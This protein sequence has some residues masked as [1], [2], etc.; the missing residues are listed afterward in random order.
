M[1]LEFRTGQS[2]Q[3]RRLAQYKFIG[4]VDGLAYFLTSINSVESRLASGLVSD[5]GVNN[6][7]IVTH[8]VPV[9]KR[10][11]FA[12]MFDK[13]I[14]TNAGHVLYGVIGKNKEDAIGFVNVW[15]QVTA[16]DSVVAVTV[17][18]KE[19]DGLA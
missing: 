15:F 2:Y 10:K 1:A 17:D 5:T 8:I 4:I 14:H 9:V 12:Y 19:G 3:D 11:G 7:D 16:R 18:H 13:P 6:A